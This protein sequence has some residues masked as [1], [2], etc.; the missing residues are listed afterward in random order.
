M[1]TSTGATSIIHK[2]FGGH[3]DQPAIDTLRHMAQRQSYPAG[4]I[5]CRQGEVEHTFYIMVEGNIMAQQTLPDGQ[6]RLLGIMKAGD[7]FGE[8]GLID[9]TPRM[10]SCIALTSVT[11]LE[12]TEAV[13]DQ[14][15]QENPTVA[16]AMTRNILTSIRNLDQLTINELQQKNEALQQAY[17]DLK[18]TQSKLVKQKRLEKEL[19]LAAVVQTSLLPDD[20]P[21]Y[22]D[23]GFAAYLAPAR[24][25]GGDFYD[26]VEID[27]EHVGLLIADVADKGFHSA[28]FMAVT[29]TLFRQEAR[30]SLSP[31]AVAMAVHEGMLDI[32]TTDDIFVT[33]VYGVLHRPSGQLTYVR[34]GH[35]RPLLARPHQP[36]EALPGGNRFLGMIPDLH[37]DEYSIHLEP[38]DRL[39]LFSDGATDAVNPAGEPY[40]QF[41][42]EDT[43]ASHTNASAP[44]LITAIVQDITQ[45]CQGAPP[46]DDLT[47]LAVEAK[48]VIPT[49]S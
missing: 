31:T 19:E 47:L 2:T 12:V 27:A 15:M 3:L 25:V 21:D 48:Q 13:F 40:D 33:A 37:L 11:V 26:V 29:R 32:A 7:Y 46:F 6:E 39:L 34:A 49:N 20:L 14:L 42:L 8:M 9:D 4:T 35:E 30:H 10:A 18:A 45:W 23:F 24:Q 38:G 43:L 22:N 5:L 17:A 28:L 1:P 44:T 36:I 16:Y 41:R